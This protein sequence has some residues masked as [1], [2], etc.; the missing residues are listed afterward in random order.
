MSLASISSYKPSLGHVLQKHDW[1]H[2]LYLVYLLTYMPMFHWKSYIF[3]C[4]PFHPND[5]IVYTHML[6]D[7]LWIPWFWFSR[8]SSSFIQEHSRNILIQIHWDASNLA[9]FHSK[10]FQ[11]LSSSTFWWIICL[12]YKGF[13]W[14]LHTRTCEPCSCDLT[15]FWP[16]SMVTFLLCTRPL[17]RGVY[18]KVTSCLIL[19]TTIYHQ[20]L[21]IFHIL[22]LKVLNIFNTSGA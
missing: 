5:G 9:F 1:Y 7:I 12:V 22:L 6:I 2:S 14:L 11:A 4:A 15:Y 10:F 13:Y 18:G 17:C 16:C 8:P 20:N 3:W 19:A 21:Y